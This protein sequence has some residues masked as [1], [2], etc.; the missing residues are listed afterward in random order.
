[1]ANHQAIRQITEPSGLWSRTH[2]LSHPCPVPPVSGVYGWYFR[3]LP[4]EFGV[5]GC[6]GYQGLTLLYVGISPK[7]PVSDDLRSRETLRRR[8]RTH[9]RGN[10][11]NSTL[12]LTLG[13]LL[14]LPL[15]ATSSGRLTFGEGEARL[16]AWMTENAFV[17]WAPTEEPWL[18]EN[19]LMQK[20]DLPLNIKGNASHPFAAELAGMRR[21][22]RRRAREAA[23]R[24]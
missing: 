15:H 16:S 6:L 19:E 23:G 9:Y 17:I 22:A 8:I 1:M 21:E 2:V 5:S 10:A 4:Y 11:D 20:L 3:Q 13:V 14:G 7:R 18:V 24:L 12:R